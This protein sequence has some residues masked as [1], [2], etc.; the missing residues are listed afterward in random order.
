MQV[1]SHEFHMLSV[2]FMFKTVDQ[3]LY[4]YTCVCISSVCEAAVA[5]GV[6]QDI[7]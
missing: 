6:E 3:I 2:M 1:H 7:H 4:L 5:Q